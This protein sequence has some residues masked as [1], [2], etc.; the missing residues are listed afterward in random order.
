MTPDWQKTTF[1]NIYGVIYIVL[2]NPT[3]VPNCTTGAS[4][5]RIHCWLM[6][7]EYEL[8][9]RRLMCC[10]PWARARKRIWQ[11]RWRDP[12]PRPG[13]KKIVADDV[14]F[15]RILSKFRFRGYTGFL[16]SYINVYFVTWDFPFSS[17]HVE[18]SLLPVV[19]HE[20]Y[21]RSL[22]ELVANSTQIEVWL[23]FQCI[24]RIL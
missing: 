4:A 13:R 10:R 12:G 16:I 15:L 8:P 18:L 7:R 5:C 3:V 21:L 17:D 20:S 11:A 23:P 9:K 14:V 24:Y 6:F 2:Q 1:I 19:T 22:E